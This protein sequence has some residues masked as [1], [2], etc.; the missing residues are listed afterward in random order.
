MSHKYPLDTTRFGV[1]DKVIF[2]P[3]TPELGVGWI[4]QKIDASHVV[5]AVG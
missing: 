2:S 3:T 1:L 4:G 5:R